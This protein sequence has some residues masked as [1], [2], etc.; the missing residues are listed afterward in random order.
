MFLDRPNRMKTYIPTNSS[1]VQTH[2][3]SLPD[4]RVSSKDI[5]VINTILRV[6]AEG[7]KDP[8]PPLNWMNVLLPLV[9]I[10]FG[11]YAI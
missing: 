6:L 2:R 5:E 9:K 7:P 3:V 10:D 8:L 4:T 1:D 11:K